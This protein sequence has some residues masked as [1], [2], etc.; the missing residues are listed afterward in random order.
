MPKTSNKWV[1]TRAFINN[2]LKEPGRYCN[3]CGM[4]YLADKEPCCNRPH[5]GTNL[6][7]MKGLLSQNKEMKKNCAKDTGANKSNTFRLGVSILPKLLEDLEDYFETN[8]KEK[9]WNDDRELKS[10][11]RNFPEFCIARKV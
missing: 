7:H 2:W 6:T 4:I 3:T 9:L 1:A 10:F 5:I 11:M 8:Y